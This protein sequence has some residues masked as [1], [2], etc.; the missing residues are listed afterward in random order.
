[1]KYQEEEAMQGLKRAVV[2]YKHRRFLLV[3]KLE[4]VP[5]KFLWSKRVAFV[6]GKVKY[7]G[8]GVFMNPND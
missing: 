6:S 4:F 1:M 7:M 2:S 8:A 5:L 3:G